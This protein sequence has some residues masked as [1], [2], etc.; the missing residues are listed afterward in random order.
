MNFQ[1]LKYFKMA[2]IHFANG[3]TQDHY[4]NEHMKWCIDIFQ[5][6]SSHVSHTHAYASKWTLILRHVFLASNHFI[7]GVM[8]NT[9]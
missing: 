6:L 4:G 2:K 9:K 5:K 1:F 8:A 3:R 7:Y